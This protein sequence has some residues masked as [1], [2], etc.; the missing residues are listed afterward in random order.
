MLNSFKSPH[1]NS[2]GLCNDQI[3]NNYYKL[4]C[5]ILENLF[6]RHLI[7]QQQSIN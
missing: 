3:M 1:I 4:H 5:E 7:L 6:F 2:L